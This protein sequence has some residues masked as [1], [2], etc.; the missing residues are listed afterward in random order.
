MLWIILIVLLA[1]AIFGPNWHG[2]GYGPAGVLG[3]VLVVLLIVYLVQ[4]IT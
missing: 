1:L 4:R 3:T 2:G